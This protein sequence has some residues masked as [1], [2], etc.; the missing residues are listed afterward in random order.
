M[1]HISRLIR[2]QPKGFFPDWQSAIALSLDEAV[3]EL[4]QRHGDDATKW[5]WGTVRP[6][7]ME[8]AFAQ[9][10]PLDRV[11][12]IGPLAG[13][14]D[15]TTVNQGGVDYASLIDRQTWVPLLR[16][17]FDVGNW[18]ACRFAMVGGQ[19]GNP[20]SPHYDDQIHAWKTGEGVEIAW[21]KERIAARTVTELVLHPEAG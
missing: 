14:G 1:G 12:N 21:T 5:T 2:E 18:D 7:V 6:L 16:S 10:P 3:A 9:Q 15:N 13:A 8:H 11:F 4:R 19:S 17:I 20:C